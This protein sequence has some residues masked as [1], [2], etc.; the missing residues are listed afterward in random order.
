MK[1]G[2]VKLK[3]RR[4]RL[5]RKPRFGLKSQARSGFLRSNRPASGYRYLVINKPYGVLTQFRDKQGRPT[6]SDY[7]SVPDVYP[8][9]RLDFD[10]EGLLILT[11]DGWL[12]HRLT[13][14]KFDHPKTYL[15]QVERVPTEESLQGLRRGI[16]LGDGPCKPVRVELLTDPPAVWERSTPIRERKNVPT[17]WLRMELREGRNRQVR[18]MT[19]AIGHP[20]LR[21]VRESSG[22][23][24]LGALQPGQWRELSAAEL[25]ALQAN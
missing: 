21:L 15:V 6:L 5:V 2:H 13:D 22:P 3:P 24:S 16:V 23:V 11:N 7:V 20:C 25:K 14:P 19:A 18:R 17:V 12:S 8:V 9:G 1:F 4:P 10:S